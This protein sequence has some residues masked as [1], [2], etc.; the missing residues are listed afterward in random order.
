MTD[1][2]D[3]LLH[4]QLSGLVTEGRR[5]DLADLDLR[6]TSELVTL[7]NAEDAAVPEAVERALPQIVAAIDAVAARMARAG[8]LIYVG[9]GTAGRLGLLDA[10]ECPPTFGVAPGTVVGLIA[11]GHA[12]VTGSVE[13]AEDDED[14]AVAD[15]DRLA[16]GERD[17]VVAVAASGRTPYA[18]AAARR[19][20]RLGALTVGVTCCPDSP[21]AGAVDHAIE[22]VVGAELLSGST[23]LK[24]GTAQKLVLNMISTVA[25]VRLG[26][27]YGNLMVDLRATNEKLRARAVGIVAQAAGVP[28]DVAAS[29]LDAAA[30]EVQPAIVHLVLGVDVVQAR[31]LLAAHDGRLR[32]ALTG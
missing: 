14:A 31:R 24:A 1:G 10:S 28:A 30:G 32:A 9:A 29:A 4:R 8:R 7:M 19:A 27:A 13:G 23:R 15:L 21:L 6:S 5:P 16:V 17:A 2:P 18:V 11:G 12:A 20:R 26:H 22:V 25:M 3:L